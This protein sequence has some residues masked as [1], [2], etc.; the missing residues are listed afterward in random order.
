VWQSS[1][2]N[3]TAELKTKTKTLN[4]KT[5]T[6]TLNLKIRQ[7]DSEPS[8]ML[9]QDIVLRLNNSDFLWSR[10]IYSAATIMF[11]ALFFPCRQLIMAKAS[12]YGDELWQVDSIPQNADR[13]S[14]SLKSLKGFSRGG[15]ETPKF[16]G[17][18]PCRLSFNK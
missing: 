6:E 1:D 17:A 13:M 10:A 4:L 9:S 7:Q 14:I 15:P 16:S 12:A 2:F 11:F 18:F 8:Q 3:K 5:R